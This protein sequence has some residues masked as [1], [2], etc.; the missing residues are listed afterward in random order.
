MITAKNTNTQLP[1]FDHNT[2]G[3]ALL[4][5]SNPAEIIPVMIN[6][7]ADVL[8]VIPPAITPTIPLTQPFC[9][10][11]PK[12]TRNPRPAII[13][14]FTPINLTPIKNNPNPANT[15]P[16]TS[17]TLAIFLLLWGNYLLNLTFY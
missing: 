16:D 12:N 13:R 15:N 2:I 8:C 17:N 10:T 9:V 4:V 3:I 11:F 7:T 14:K 6:V 5:L 1:V